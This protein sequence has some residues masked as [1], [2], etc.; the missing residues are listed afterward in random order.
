M[1]NLGKG[2]T[3]HDYS[4]N[5]NSKKWQ[6]CERSVLKR[7]N[8]SKSQ[9]WKVEFRKGQF[10]NGNF[11]KIILKKGN[12]GE[13]KTNTYQFWKGHFWTST[14]LEMRYWKRVILKMAILKTTI[15]KKEPFGKK[16]NSGKGNSEEDNSEKESSEKVNCE[17]GQ[18][19]WLSWRF[20][21]AFSAIPASGRNGT[22]YSSNGVYYIFP[23]V[24]LGGVTTYM[25]SV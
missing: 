6:V 14:I 20:V 4:E 16:D 1:T 25:L 10:C 11:W 5:A 13:G 15:L 18:L 23:V 22:L 2:K 12:S 21:V 24:I 3:G 8:L 9:S 7:N 19:P 17:K